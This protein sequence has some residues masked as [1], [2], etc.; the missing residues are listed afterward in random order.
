[1][2][3]VDTW[4]PITMSV[5]CRLKLKAFTHYRCD[6]E[7][8]W[9]QEYRKMSLI[10]AA[11]SHIKVSRMPP[12]VIIIIDSF[13]YHVVIRI[14]SVVYQKICNSQLMGHAWYANIW[15]IF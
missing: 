5:M 4:W 2:A 7:C 3:Y 6:P 1:M 9:F 15:T 8:V 12:L 13:I 14:V 10:F 11:K